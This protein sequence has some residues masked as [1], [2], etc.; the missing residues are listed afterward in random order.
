MKT[1]A[2]YPKIIIHRLGNPPVIQRRIVPPPL[3]AGLLVLILIAAGAALGQR[4]AS[5]PPAWQA[6]ISR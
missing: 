3:I 5:M 6:S 4:Q 2:S 1:T